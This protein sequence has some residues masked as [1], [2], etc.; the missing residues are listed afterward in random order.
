MNETIKAIKTQ[1]QP[2]VLGIND[3]RYVLSCITFAPSCVDMGWDWEVESIGSTTYDGTERLRGYALR[4][5]FRRPE[6][7]SGEIATGYGRWWF[8]PHDIT[9]SGIVKT[10]FAAAKMILEHEIMESF[11]WQGK[12][13]FDPH[14]SVELLAYLQDDSIEP[15]AAVSESPMKQRGIKLSVLDWFILIGLSMATITFVI[16]AMFG[17]HQAFI[18]IAQYI[19]QSMN[20]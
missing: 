18:G 3:V 14:N 10:A 6:R 11:K 13:V 17:L 4:T 19:S 9:V 7:E 5:T 16:L 12:R 8:V 2:A 1:H 20:Q 15:I